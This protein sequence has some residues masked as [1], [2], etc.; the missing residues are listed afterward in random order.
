M[1]IKENSLAP[2]LKKEGGYID[3]ACSSAMTINDRVAGTDKATSFPR[4]GVT[5]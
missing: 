2:S 5:R 4:S 3:N 1:C